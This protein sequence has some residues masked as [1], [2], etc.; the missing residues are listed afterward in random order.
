M[1]PAR[2]API[3][4]SLILTGLMTLVATG[5]ATAT[6]GGEGALLERWLLRGWL[7]AWAVAFPLV[8]VVTPLT[9]RLVALLTR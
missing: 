9:R 6:A 2:Y 3:L 4:F 7:P 1:I 8:M 5:I